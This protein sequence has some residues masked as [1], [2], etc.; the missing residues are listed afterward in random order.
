[1]EQGPNRFKLLKLFELTMIYFGNFNNAR[2]V[3]VRRVT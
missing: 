1:M 3:A 2:P